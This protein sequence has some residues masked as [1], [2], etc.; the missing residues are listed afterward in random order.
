MKHHVQCRIWIGSTPGLR[1]NR[2]TLVVQRLD[3]TYSQSSRRQKRA[4]LEAGCTAMGPS[5]RRWP[6]PELRSAFLIEQEAVQRFP[7]HTR[8]RLVNDIQNLLTVPVQA[9]GTVQV[10]VAFRAERR[11]TKR[12]SFS[13]PYPRTMRLD[14]ED[15]VHDAPVEAFQT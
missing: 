8:R 5:V 4:F 1:H 11:Q 12:C 7:P 3:E 15:K 14:R 9:E 6:S 13:R 10:D 2:D